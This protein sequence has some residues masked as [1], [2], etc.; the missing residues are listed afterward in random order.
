[1]IISVEGQEATGKSTLLYTAPLPIVCFS[2]DMGHERSL[3]G[4]K[5]GEF[6]KGLKIEFVK[7]PKGTTESYKGNDITV[8]ELPPPIQLDPMRVVGY[9][10]QWEYFVN[11]FAE[12]IQDDEVATVGIDT[13]TI[14]TKNKRDAYLQELQKKAQPG[15]TP[16][17]QL[18]QIEYG[19]PDGQIRNL[20][21]SASSMGKNLIAV[22]HLRDHYAPMLNADGQMTTGP[23]GTL[24]IDGIKDTPR[25]VDIRLTNEK[26]G[27]V[28]SSKFTKCG[29]NLELEGTTIPNLNW[30][31]LVNILEMNWNGRPF[32]RRKKNN[33]D[34]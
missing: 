21:T 27:G 18:Q 16:R 22:H 26:K 28:I 11:L 8:F 34:N 25:F 13:M 17:K 20:Y 32:P 9:M 30:D 23:D 29:Y 5:F 10:E 33:G 1:M 7:Y 12:L 15:Q 24:E 19:H 14:L 3:Y 6:F 2:L 4:A 31:S